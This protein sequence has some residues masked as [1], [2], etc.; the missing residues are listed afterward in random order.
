MNVAEAERLEK[1]RE[2]V[3]NAAE[4]KELFDGSRSYHADAELTD[5]FID[6]LYREIKG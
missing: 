2:N 6:E 5:E 1:L 3:E 4:I